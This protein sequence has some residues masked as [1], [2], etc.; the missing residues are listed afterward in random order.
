[1]KSLRP[2]LS[3]VL[4]H[5]GVLVL[6]PMAASAL[7]VDNLTVTNGAD[8]GNLTVTGHADVMGTAEV[9][10]FRINTNNDTAP[11]QRHAWRRF[12][13][14]GNDTSDHTE[15]K[16]VA[17]LNANGAAWAGIAFEGRI[18]NHRTNHGAYNGVSI[19]FAG[20]VRGF[21]A[22]GNALNNTAIISQGLAETVNGQ[23]Y[24]LVR[25]VRLQDN[26]FELQ[27]RTS[28]NYRWTEVEW[29]I[30]GDYNGAQTIEYFDTGPLVAGSAGIGEILPTYDHFSS[31]GT[32]WA[33]KIGVNTTA[34]AAA[35]D[36]V[37]DIKLTGNIVGATGTPLLRSSTSGAILGGSTLTAQTAI[38]NTG[39]V[40]IG[41]TPVSGAGKIQ[42]PAGTT[43][44]NGIVFGGDTNLYR[45][46]SG[47]LHTDSILS[48]AKGLI[49]DATF[50]WSGTAPYQPNGA[51]QQ[52]TYIDFGDTRF[53]GWMEVS[54]SSTHSYQQATGRLTKRFEIGRNP[55]DNGSH[56][57]TAEVVAA[58]GAIAT[59]WKMGNPQIFEGR[60]RIPLYHL[61]A[62]GNPLYVQIQGM[63]AP[64]GLP[65]ATF[66]SGITFTAPT[67]LENTETRDYPYTLS[68]RTGFGGPPTAGRIQLA[69]S[70]TQAGGIYWGGDTNLYRGAANVLKT[71]D[72]LI[73][74]D[75]LGV[76][77][78]APAA[79]LDVQGDAKISG[80]LTVAGASVLTTSGGS[81]ANLT[82]LNAAQLTTG[83]L[84]ISRLPS[85]VVQLSANQTLSS[86]TLSGAKLTGVTT[87]GG[88]TAA[89]QVFVDSSGNV[90][91]GTSAPSGKLNVSGEAQYYAN[92]DSY[93]NSAY[94]WHRGTVQ[95]RRARGTQTAPINVANG[96][97]LGDISFS[98]WN[99]GFTYASAHVLGTVDG[100]PGATYTPAKLAFY[101]SDG[102][103][104]AQ[105]RMTISAN[106][107]VGIGVVTPAAKLDVNGAAQF[108]GDVKIKNR[109]VIRVSPAGD[110]PMIANPVGT[111]PEL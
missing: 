37:G 86:K 102:V 55:G 44:A 17:R 5:V 43:S 19:P 39:E 93:I 70:T 101:T 108:A 52:V 21:T 27:A 73:V 26:D 62:T 18:F 32:L 72:S 22:T 50:I 61:V 51:S 91:V 85:E 56:L 28:G 36:V 74:V 84:P 20:A 103:T 7:E 80:A 88:N 68:E 60:L 53:W 13:W 14:G 71:D 97:W 89:Q 57:G 58:H 31:A 40:G 98:A 3:I 8:V 35:L 100:V 99:N 25:L 1:M 41:T 110:I 79:K 15:W 76:G 94:Y 87:L 66:L 16:K 77:T 67:T 30:T 65:T 38:S 24:P 64:S 49:A 12:S 46:Q 106:G 111:N 78:A 69:E 95:F 11:H 59:Q 82:G 10:T 9:G 75:K 48:T 105:S 81:G 109:A 107:N 90:G 54:L 104:A 92:F 42:L 4:A 83:T 96:D 23:V 33:G 47:T 29:R 6:S 63:R 45:Q 34:P 2:H